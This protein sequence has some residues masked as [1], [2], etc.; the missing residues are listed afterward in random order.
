MKIQNKYIRRLLTVTA[1]LGAVHLAQADY[2]TTV[3]ADQPAGYWRLDDA[4]ALLPDISVTNKGTAG[5]AANGSF[6]GYVGREEEGA[7]NG[8]SDKAMRFWG[9]IAEVSRVLM[10][11][12][13]NFNFPGTTAF[14]LE[15]WAKPM[16]GLTS[17][18]GTQRLFS[19]GSSQNGFGFGIQNHN[20][21][22]ITGHSVAD[23]TSDA[24]SS[25]FASNQWYHVAMVRSNTSVFFY[26]NGVQLGNPKS[27][28]NIKTS[29]NALALGRSPQGAGGEGFTG[30]MDEPAV[31]ATALSPERITAHYQAGLN[32]G[33]GYE[34]IVLADSPVGYWRLN[35]PKKVQSTSEIANLGNLGAAANGKVF[36]SPGSLESGAIGAITGDANPAMNF[37]GTDAH[38]DIP[39]LAGLNTP[40]YSV[41]AWVKL[42]AYSGTASPLTSRQSV[43]GGEAS[44][45]MLYAYP[46][47]NQPRWEFWNG[48]GTGWGTANAGAADGVLNK[49][50]HLVATYD[51]TT[52][53]SLLYVDGRVSRGLTNAPQMLNRTTPLRI[54][55]GSSELLFGQYFL[56][57]AIDEVAIYPSA[58]SPQ[59]V[60]AHYEAAT[61]AAPAVSAP[62]FAFAPLGQTNWAPHPVYVSCV[63]TGSLPMNL[64][65]YRVGS[66]GVSTTPVTGGTNMVLTLSPTSPELNGEYYLTASNTGGS[67]DSSRVYVELIPPAAPQIT[68]DVPSETPVYAGGTAGIPLIVTNTPPFS[69]Q[70][71]SNSV[72]IP[73]GTNQ[74]L[75][76]RNAKAS[77]SSAAYQARI[78]NPAGSATSASGSIVVKTPTAATYPAVITAMNP[79]AFWR[80]GEVSGNVAFDYWGG[81]PAFFMNAMQGASGALLQDDD[82]A[83]ASYG[84]GSY[85]RTIE[86][87]IFNF[88]GVQPFTLAAW[89]R[90]DQFPTGGGRARF[91]STR[92]QVGVSGGFGLGFLNNNTLR[93]TGY[94]VADADASVPSFTAG[95]WYH[96]AAVRSNTTVYLYI[97]GALANSGTVASIR[98]SSQ[99]LQFS[100][101][102]NFVAATDEEPFSGTID[103]AAVFDRALTSQEVGALYAARQGALN[104]PSITQEPATAQTY[105]G[106]TARFSVK[107]DGSAP[108]LY[109]WRTNGVAIP[110][111]TNATL[112]VTNVALAQN[113]WNY[114]VRVSNQAGYQDSMNASL[115]VMSP[116][117]YASAVLADNPVALWRLNETT[118]P[119]VHDSWGGY[120]GADSSTVL[121]GTPGG[122]AGSTDT[123]A[124]FD[125]YSS[126]VEVPFAA[127]LNP[128]VF[129]VECWARVAGGEG[130][131]RTVIST[132]DELSTGWRKGFIIYATAQNRWSFWTSVGGTDGGWQTLDGPVVTLNEWTHL[133]AIYD[134]ATK[135]F[136]V[137]GKLVG[138]SAV[139]AEPN[140]IRPLRIGAGKNESDIAMY[141]FNGDIDDVALYNK[142]LTPENVTYHYSLGK[143]S[144]NTAPFI[145]RHP[146]SLG[147]LA[148]AAAEFSAQAE[149][150][151]VLAYQWLHNGLP[152][153]GA[154]ND[155]LV[156]TNTTF[157]DAGDYALR[158]ANSINAITSQVAV[159]KLG[160]QPTFANLTNDLVLHL[161]FENNAQDAS[162]RNNHGT[163]V[164]APTFVAGRLG[165]ALHYRTAGSSYNYVTL[166]SPSDL[167]FGDAD[168]SVSYW[169]RFT[170]ATNLPFLCNSLLPYGDAGLSFTAGSG[171]FAW[172][173]KGT[174]GSAQ[175]GFATQPI[176]NGAWHHLVHTFD[177]SG[178]AITYLNG[179]QVDSRSIAAV[180]S[181]DAINPFNIGQDGTGALSVDAEADIDDLGIW[182][183]AL[184]PYEA[185]SIYAAA[186]VSGQSF[187][188]AGPVYLQLVPSTSGIELIWQSGTLVESTSLT[189]AYTPVPDAKAPYHKITPGPGAK[190]YRIKL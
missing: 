24:M 4:P 28:A 57:G 141:Y 150:S 72:N 55:A 52:R 5:S 66:D 49:W 121:Y 48:N 124:T 70:W 61:G 140:I 168:F 159:L 30:V 127:A 46:V 16:M 86:S 31:Y 148:G 36:G 6:T 157:A 9:N 145:V 153:A 108:L 69:Y 41:E 172:S 102:P 132:R 75:A 94:G 82:G 105:A 154:T 79:M 85:V 171:N 125:G 181:L 110:G 114:S 8:S 130:T 129:S 56:N 174:T 175:T 64:Q 126:K 146:E 88:P 138:T 44:G 65:W 131:Y 35:E 98:A 74:V 91:F 14:T 37:T 182:N 1:L 166:G 119:V 185:Y 93:F 77:Y 84:S 118:G 100:G 78:T 90:A 156:L 178:N 13:E 135:Y 80:F 42:N 188:V 12:K 17:S 25:Q 165:Q 161:K 23:V 2:S 111:A 20:T 107:A 134:G 47:S 163:V 62:G 34:D 26:V 106:G 117:G 158:V 123:A 183:K 147:L 15:V 152:V 139:I 43:S 81:K 116:S 87:G 149:G 50:T 144:D 104:P 83:F 71:Q 92:Q 164:G 32:N 179:Q 122:I 133:A 22:R 33:A 167:Q 45:Y 186:N 128:A 39:Q 103:D 95:E 60:Q 109:Q 97:N 7:L 29:T 99:P 160:A 59:R 190:F 3:L 169:V 40:S 58:L 176:N 18:S 112:A 113:G 151:P 54:G 21:L 89:V 67:V 155:S 68:L 187:D 38:I 120:N 96:I 142:P 143:Y 136:Y 11:G 170:S 184:T 189:G 73:D 10:G 27:L 177:R 101:N 63:V 115:S 19:N 162:G 137:N 51:A 180:G 53:Q 173:M 76:I